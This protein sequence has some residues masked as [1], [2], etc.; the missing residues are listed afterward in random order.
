M[1]HKH[2]KSISFAANN[3]LEGARFAWRKWKQEENKA[4]TMLKQIYEILWNQD[5]HW[6]NPGDH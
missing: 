6:D 2:P 4:R 1:L 3:Q 5:Q